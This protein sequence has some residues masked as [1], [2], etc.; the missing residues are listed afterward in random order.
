MGYA[1]TCALVGS[2]PSLLGSACGAEINK[3]VRVFRVN[4]PVLTGFERD[5]GNFTTHLYLRRVHHILLQASLAASHTHPNSDPE[6][7]QPKCKPLDIGGGVDEGH[8]AVGSQA[9]KM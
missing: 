7:F 8:S 4:S 9:Q 3:H 5:V 6:R 2:D 1:H